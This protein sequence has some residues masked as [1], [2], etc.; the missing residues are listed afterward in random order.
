MWHAPYCPRTNAGSWIAPIILT[1]LR[2]GSHLFLNKDGSVRT[3]IRPDYR[4][5]E[6]RE[7]LAEVLEDSSLMELIITPIE[8]PK[9]AG[10]VSEPGF[11]TDELN[12]WPDPDAVKIGDPPIPQIGISSVDSVGGFC[13]GHG[14]IGSYCW[15]SGVKGRTCETREDWSELADPDR[16]G[17]TIGS[18]KGLVTVL[19]DESSPGRVTRVQL[20]PVLV[21]EP[22]LELGKEVYSL[23]A[24]EGETI[25]L[26]ELPDVS[27]GVYLLVTSYE[28]PLGHVEHGFKVELSKRWANE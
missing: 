7:R 3:S 4:S 25:A 16:Y 22:E 8:C 10:M 14:W 5:D 26:F 28:S 9:P 23:H 12:G 2:S 1:D 27:R 18:H 11:C 21:E 19:G 6:G 15:Q 13:I 20:F 24:R 17:M